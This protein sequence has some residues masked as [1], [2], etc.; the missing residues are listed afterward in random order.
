VFVKYYSPFWVVIRTL[1][2]LTYAVPPELALVM[3]M[4]ILF[5]LGKLRAKNIY[6]INPTKIRAAGRVSIMVFDKTGTLTESGLFVH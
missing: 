1:D 3:S 5:S 6:C 4:G 2:T